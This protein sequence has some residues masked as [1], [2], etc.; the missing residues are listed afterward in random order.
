MTTVVLGV[1]LPWT[2][3]QGIREERTNYRGTKTKAAIF[4]PAAGP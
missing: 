1:L 2:T 3:L 4:F